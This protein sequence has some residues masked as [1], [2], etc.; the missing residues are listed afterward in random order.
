VWPA[1]H[2]QPLASNVNVDKDG[3]TIANLAIV[4]LG[5]GGQV[6]LFAFSEVDLLVDVLGYFTADTVPM[7][8]QGLF[9]PLGPARIIDTRLVAQDSGLYTPKALVGGYRA[10]LQVAG[11]GGVPTTGVAAVIGNVTA[12]ET[13]A[14]GFIT[15]YPAATAQP[16]ASNVNIDRAG[17]TIPNLVVGRLGYQGRLSLF[18]YAG[19]DVLFD[20]AGWFT[21]VPAPPTPGVPLDPPP[22]TAHVDCGFGG[23][24]AGSWPTSCWRPYGDHSPF[25]RLVPPDPKLAPNSQAIVDRV[26]GM[27]PIADLV[28]AP[29]TSSDWY[30]PVYYSAPTDPLFTVHCTGVWSGCEVEG[31]QVRIPDPARPASGGD[32]HLAVVDQAAGWEYD[33]W[34]VEDKPMGGGVLSVEWGGRTEIK[35]DGL[36]SDAT[37]AHFG[38]LAGAI[39]AQELNAGRI[40][41]ALFM[42]VGC[43]SSEYVY[44]ARGHAATCADE[45]NAPATGQYLW[46][47]MTD[48]EIDTLDMPS[49]KKT[50]LH[51]LSRHGAFVGDTGGNEAFTFQFESGSTYTSFG[52]EDA[53]ATFARNQTAGVTEWDGKYYFD[54]GSGVDWRDRLRVL[55]PC[56]AE[57]TC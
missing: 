22:A 7:S 27:G 36:A 18:T 17:Q 57:R 46:L 56:V 40:D 15:V 20:V 33:F 50:I 29:D 11:Y 35:G 28:V 48:T 30:H 55:D 9:M 26:L 14:P 34:H 37:A 52:M 2:A 51:A 45:A 16:L 10:D 5:A 43:T 4:P 19:S 8:D 23:F 38:L 12:T 47:A 39:R 6:S 42:M 49:W 32:A 25:N 3:Q 24:R 31:M 44:P 21:G 53:A 1:G 54:L 13:A 41:H